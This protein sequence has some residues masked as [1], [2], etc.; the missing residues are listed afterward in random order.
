METITP[1]GIDP[2]HLSDTA[3]LGGDVYVTWDG[4]A[5]HLLALARDDRRAH[6]IALAPDMIHALFL[7]CESRRIP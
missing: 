2:A 1:Y 3:C 7:F 4:R 5:L 6:R